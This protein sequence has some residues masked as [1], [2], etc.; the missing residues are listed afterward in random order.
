M[1]ITA[2]KTA[3]DLCTMALR[4]V[5]VVRK[6]QPASAEDMSVAID[7]LDLMLKE[8]QLD[9]LKQFERTTGSLPVTGATASYLISPRVLRIQ[10]ARWKDGANET[11]LE[12]LTGREYDALPNKAATGRATSYF[13]DR[14]ATTGTLIVWPVLTTANSETIE[15]T[16]QR[17]VEDITQST[18]VIDAP[19]EY[20]SAITWNLANELMADYPVKN[21]VRA[22]QITATAARKYNEVQGYGRPEYFEF[23][24][25]DD[26]YRF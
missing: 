10:S 5:G 16:G 20:Y 9:G 14:Q 18:D 3:G 1:A 17:E 19:S 24:P 11:D 8:W 12:S 15:W 13:Y 23:Q 7:T 2:T 22:Q 4:R 25:D 6:G 21:A 26:G